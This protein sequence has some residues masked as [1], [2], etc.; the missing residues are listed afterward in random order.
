LAETDFKAN[1]YITK[2]KLIKKNIE[3]YRQSAGAIESGNRGAFRKIGGGAE[4]CCHKI[5]WQK[6]GGQLLAHDL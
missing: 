4:V 6:S 1:L 3:S 2:K 5:I